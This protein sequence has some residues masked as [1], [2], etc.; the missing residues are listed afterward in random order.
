MIAIVSFLLALPASAQDQRVVSVW[1]GYEY[2]TSYWAHC[3]SLLEGHLAAADLR[4]PFCEYQHI[5]N[6]L[7]DGWIVNHSVPIEEPLLTGST[8]VDG[9][10]LI[11]LR[12]VGTRYYLTREEGDRASEAPELKHIRVPEALGGATA[13][14]PSGRD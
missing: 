9:C 12:C 1:E 3:Q 10:Y 4:T 11:D 8:M 2:R 13:G 7:R 5:D 6:L 14:R